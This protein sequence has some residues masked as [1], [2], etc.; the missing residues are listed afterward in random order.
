[1]KSYRDTSVPWGTT[2]G[3]IV[4]MLSDRDIN[5]VQFTN[6]S[7]ETAERSG[8]SLEDGTIAII[9]VFQKLVQ[10]PDGT[11]GMIPVRIMVPNV[12]TDNRSLNQYYRLLYW[13]LKSK[14]EAIDTGLVEFAEE[15]MAHLQIGDN[16][17]GFG[18]LWD[19]F[20]GGYYKAIGSGT[21]PESNLLPPLTKE[22]G[23]ENN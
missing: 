22:D 1:M 11:S 4:K 19:K 16:R 8:L 20:K 12:Y 21:M 3:Q 13:Y 6:I 15:F 10:L 9:L 7:K 14:F 2:Q 23:D 17:G 5:D 18:R